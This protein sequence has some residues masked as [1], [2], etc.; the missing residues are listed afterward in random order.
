MFLDS[1]KNLE[2]GEVDQEVLTIPAP[3]PTGIAVV[4]R[5][6]LRIWRKK[7]F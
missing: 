3:A 1:E 4:S 6:K 7:L 5:M 2:E